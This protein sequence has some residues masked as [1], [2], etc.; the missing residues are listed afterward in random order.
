MD[1]KTRFYRFEQ[2]DKK[3]AI[4]NR[5]GNFFEVDKLG[6]DAIGVLDNNPI[7]KAVEILSA[8][9][10]PKAVKAAVASLKDLIDDKVK[11]SKSKVAKKSTPSAPKFFYVTLN[12]I[13]ECNLVCKYCWNDSGS[14][15][16]EDEHLKMGEDIAFK[17]VDLLIKG[18]GNKKE[19]VVDLYGGEP[20]L[21]FELV[22]KVVNYC[23]SREKD[24]K[25]EFHFLLATNGTM[26]TPEK[27]KFLDDNGVDIAISI[28]GE[29]EMQ[30]K[31]R[32]FRSGEGTYDIIMKNLDKIPAGLRK[33]MV[34]R[35]T[36]TPFNPK[37]VEIFKTLRGLGFERIE[38]CE[39]EDVCFGMKREKAKYF[40][41]NKKDVEVLKHEYERLAKFY[42]DEIIAGSFNYYNIYFNR[43]FKMLARLYHQNKIWGCCS[44]GIG[45]IAVDAKGDIYPCTTFL[46]IKA[47][48]IGDVFKGIDQSSKRILLDSEIT[49]SASCDKCFAKVLCK[50]AGS[51]Y[52]INY[53]FNKSITEPVE[54]FCDIFR[55][56]TKLMIAVIAAINA[57]KPHLLSELLKIPS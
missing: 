41:K 20:T 56:K 22:K 31:M 13:N 29:K 49:T 51:C 8:K 50:G 11:P 26:L 32:P 14:Y 12:L 19:L 17:A 57:K 10:D 24:S 39:T 42:V 33:R 34:A 23:K 25:K 4:D 52:N 16:K 53:Y 35:A 45:Q 3:F 21:N 1:M 37:I 46:D 28:D 6:W 48:K 30:D 5:T 38:I 47:F 40:F 44:A 36:V 2:W 15:S 18:S 55:F 27:A 9:Y 43:F 54:D 7:G